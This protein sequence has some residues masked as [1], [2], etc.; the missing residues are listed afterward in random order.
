MSNEQGG[1]LG[2]V[3]SVFGMVTKS[4]SVGGLLEACVYG[5]VGAVSGYLAVTFIKWL[6]KKL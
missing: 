4:I 5:A 3:G 6:I 1:V 2:L